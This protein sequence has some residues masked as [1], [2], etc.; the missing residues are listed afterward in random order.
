MRKIDAYFEGKI[1]QVQAICADLSIEELY[2]FG[3]ACNGKFVQG[4][5][6]LDIFIKT[7]VENEKNLVRLSVELSKLYNCSV[8][9]FHM[10][11]AMHPEIQE[12][13]DNNKI[14]VYKNRRNM[15]KQHPQIPPPSE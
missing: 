2:F 13:L 3:S 10:N 5:S 12:H 7:S 4:K 1:E 15:T 11:W 9:T 6:D 14:L 8:D